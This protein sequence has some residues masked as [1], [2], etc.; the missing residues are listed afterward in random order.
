METTVVVVGAGPTG[1][2]LGCELGLAGVPTVL[3]DAEPER[4]G[5]SRA[6]GVTPR[7]AE[8][9]DLRGLLR[10]LL[11]EAGMP[12]PDEGHFAD[13]PVS[14]EPLD[15]R[16][17]WLLIPQLGMERFLE[18]RLAALGVPLLRGHRL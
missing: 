12:G 7:T 9:L 1:L 11:D 13:L 14:P 10:P 8:V 5:L 4:P 3:V 15:S 6:G 2:M 16:Y 18:R 17:P